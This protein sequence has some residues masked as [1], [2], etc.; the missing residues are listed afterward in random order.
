[1][2]DRRAVHR[3]EGRAIESLNNPIALGR[4][5]DDDGTVSLATANLVVNTLVEYVA[6]FDAAKAAFA[7]LQAQAESRDAASHGALQ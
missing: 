3:L 2:T 5:L 6:R 1:M 7:E 4:T